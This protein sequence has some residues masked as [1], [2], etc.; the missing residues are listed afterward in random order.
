MNDRDERR[1]WERIGVEYNPPLETP[2]DEMWSVIEHRIGSVDHPSSSEPAATG[3]SGVSEDES[4]VIELEAARAQRIAGRTA[5]QA[6][7]LRP[8][9]G[10]AVAAAA[11]LVLGVGIGRMSVSP[12]TMAGGGTDGGPGFASAPALAG[13]GLAA[14]AHLGRTEAL[15]TMVRADARDGRVDPAVGVWAED[16]LAQTRLLL[17]RPQGVEPGL[18]DLLLDLELVLVQVVGLAE[19]DSDDAQA[20]TEVEL[21]LKS[22]DEGEVL[23]RI[24]AQIPL[25]M[26]GV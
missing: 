3:A 20:R 23:P 6:H 9:L 1:L 5:E 8:A 2:R 12:A 21:T 19:T 4:A 17:D 18:Q 11:L 25:S 24:Q 22:L 15:L 7:R 16:L 14:R 10:W 13:N 26:A